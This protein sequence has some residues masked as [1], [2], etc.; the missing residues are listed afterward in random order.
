[1]TLDL[2]FCSRSYFILFI[3]IRDL[4]FKILAK[5]MCVTPH[6]RLLT[7]LYPLIT[8]HHV[9][10]YMPRMHCVL[11]PKTTRPSISEPVAAPRSLKPLFSYMPLPQ[12]LQCP[13]D[14]C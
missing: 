9:P 10:Q 12:H 6:S 2:I 5:T 4:I 1:M 11:V 3:L 14:A 8:Y 13:V 7:L